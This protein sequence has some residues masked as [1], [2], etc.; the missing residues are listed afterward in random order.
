MEFVSAITGVGGRG[1]CIGGWSGGS[2]TFCTS[3]VICFTGF[4]LQLPEGLWA[5]STLWSLSDCCS[6]AWR[7]SRYKTSCWATEISTPGRVYWEI[8]SIWCKLS[9]TLLVS[10]GGLLE[11]VSLT[12]GSAV[13]EPGR[14]KLNSLELPAG[15][16]ITQSWTSPWLLHLY[17]KLLFSHG[18]FVFLFS[19]GHGSLFLFLGLFAF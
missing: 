7:Y 19:E 14:E 15:N 10:S 12:R 3:T 11:A 17:F 1:G 13:A 2:A 16:K 4:T 5:C 6:W 18:N 8:V 9:A